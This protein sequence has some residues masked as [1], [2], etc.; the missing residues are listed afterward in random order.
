MYYPLL[1]F[2]FY[3]YFYPP[4]RYCIIIPTMSITVVY[5][6]R[7]GTCERFVRRI[8]IR[9][10]GMIPSKCP[11]VFTQYTTVAIGTLFPTAIVCPLGLQQI[12]IFSPFVLTVCVTLPAVEGGAGQAS[13]DSHMIKH[14]SCI[15]HPDSLVARGSHQDV[16]LRRVPAQLVHTA[17]VCLVV[18][19]AA[20]SRDKERGV[21]KNDRSGNESSWLTY[22]PVRFQTPNCDRLIKRATSQSAT[23]A[24][25]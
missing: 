14:T 19:I 15:P 17:R 11:W 6:R 16:R 18:T 9:R 24:A 2:Q 22:Q 1:Y 3:F 20:L 10:N 25:P 4:K 21:A 8:G 13:R 7:N 5:L 12:L 23:V